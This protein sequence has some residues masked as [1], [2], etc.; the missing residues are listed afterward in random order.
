MHGYT[1]DSL[2]FRRWASVLAG[3]FLVAF[4]SIYFFHVSAKTEDVERR[5]E[6]N[7]VLG[8]LAFTRQITQMGQ[9]TRVVTSNPDG[10]DSF[11]LPTSTGNFVSEHG[12]PTEPGSHMP[13]LP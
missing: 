11:T 6:D 9:E 3:L 2:S 7:L 10:S 4:S 5:A 13:H 12:R 1:L 8:R